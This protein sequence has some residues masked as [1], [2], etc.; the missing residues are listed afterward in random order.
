[1]RRK[2]NELEIQT[3]AYLY[4]QQNYHQAEIAKL[5]KLSPAVV[6]RA[7]EQARKE[8]WLVE[9]PELR[10]I[11]KRRLE[12]IRARV[13][14]RSLIEQL[15]K[16]ASRSAGMAIPEV[17]VFPVPSEDSLEQHRKNQEAFGRMA[18][19]RV[20]ELL[21]SSKGF[22]GVSW[23]NTIAGI[24]KG[25]GDIFPSPPR[26]RK[27]FHFLPL[28]GEP[29]G[30]SPTRFSASS[31]SSQLDSI[32]NGGTNHAY[33]LAAVPAL[34]P[35]DFSLKEEVKTIHKLISHVEAYREIFGE[36]GQRET[37]RGALIT[38]VD[39]ILTS[40][41]PAERTLGFG[42]D[43]FVKTAG[44]N[45]EELQRLVIGDIGGVLFSR[46]GLSALDQ[47]AFEQIT[48]QWT[49]ITEGQMRLCVEEARKNKASGIIIVAIGKHKAKIVYECV[50]RGLANHLVVS[51]DIVE[52]L[53]QL[54]QDDL[55]EAR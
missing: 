51:Q 5:M 23:G 11:S 30:R 40:V 46:P 16:S 32:M 28:C 21:L 39:T 12:E 24:V 53:E 10:N 4:S 31:L 8:N 25:I 20:A 48:R 54:L 55:K 29:L 37:P 38:Q 17:H 1:M 13:T 34:I 35:R 7:L 50:K 14:P 19:S 15:E 43:E 9:K 26:K 49:G 33:S 27:P 42:D 44:I 52:A 45:R 36:P 6:S 2:V 3:A 41:G 47:K 18:A 22:I